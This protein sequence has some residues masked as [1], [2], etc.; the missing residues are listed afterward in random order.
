[1]GRARRR[2]AGE[3]P[4]RG[5]GT[6]RA[7]RR[8]RARAVS[9]LARERGGGGGVIRKRDPRWQTAAERARVAAELIE[10]AESLTETS[11]IASPA[12]VARANLPPPIRVEL[13]VEPEPAP[14]EVPTATPPAEAV[15]PSPDEMLAADPANVA[16]L[17]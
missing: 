6:A 14:A 15:A 3:A 7:A 10:E 11:T 8:A 2:G 5:A 4:V 9:R 12:D 1:V 16:P 17:L 13:P